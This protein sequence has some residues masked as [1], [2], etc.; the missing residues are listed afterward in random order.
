MWNRDT[1]QLPIRIY[2]FCYMNGIHQI[3]LLQ[4]GKTCCW[5]AVVVRNAHRRRFL[6]DPQR[7]E[8]LRHAISLCRRA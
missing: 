1:G 3:H 5:A 4:K 2:G 7:Y 8:R 6:D